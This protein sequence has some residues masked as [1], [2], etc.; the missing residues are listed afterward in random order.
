[1]SDENKAAARRVVERGFNEGRL[2]VIDEVV[3]QD[4]VGHDPV[5]PDDTVGIDGLK[6][7][8]EAFREA[9]LDLEVSLEEVVADGDV[10]ATRW[11]ARGTHDGELMGMA[12]TGRSTESHGMTIDRFEDAKLVE[13]WDNW[14][15]LGL[16]QQIGALPEAETA[17]T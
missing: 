10:V 2:E 17:A 4:F 14:N 12:A 8:I 5:D 13:S 9:F 16:L 1:M 6:A 7:R 11:V 3:G 15:A